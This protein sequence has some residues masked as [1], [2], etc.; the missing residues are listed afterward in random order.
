MNVLNIGAQN[1][2]DFPPPSAPGRRDGDLVWQ[3]LPRF[4]PDHS[5]SRNGRLELGRV[6]AGPPAWDELRTRTALTM[7][8]NEWHV[9]GVT[10][11]TSGCGTTT[12]AFN[13][14]AGLARQNNCRVVL[15]ELNLRRPALAGL[16][17]FDGE[18]VLS[19]YLLGHRSVA[20]SL[21]RMTD[22]LAI[23]FNTRVENR[24]SEIL[25]DAGVQ[26][27]IAEL[28]RQL[29]PDCVVLDLPAMI[30][31]DDVLACLP[32]L[33]CALLVA[34]ANKSTFGEID[35]CERELS[36]RTSMLGVVLNMCRD[37]PARYGY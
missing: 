2:S 8:R 3:K 12:V 30:G 25:L 23:G 10:A 4:S 7:A 11:P 20:D 5:I 24:P 16:M 6:G 21:T 19:E 13:L 22:C 32:L 17:K 9:L 18:A 26:L 35:L 15:M 27:A 37:G 1:L 28:R 31:A 29:N 14:A 36:E 33:D 34:G